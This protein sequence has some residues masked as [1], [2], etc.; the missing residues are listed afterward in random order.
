MESRIED[1]QNSLQD[2]HYSCH[3]K[4]LHNFNYARSFNTSENFTALSTNNQSNTNDSPDFCNNAKVTSTSSKRE[5]LR[6]HKGDRSL[7]IIKNNMWKQP[8][9][10]NRKV[11]T[12]RISTGSI[13]TKFLPFISHSTPPPPFN[14]PKNSSPLSA[15]PQQHKLHRSSVST[16]PSSPKITANQAVRVVTH[17]TSSQESPQQHHKPFYAC[18]RSTRSEGIITSTIFENQDHTSSAD[19]LKFTTSKSRVFPISE[20]EGSSPSD[21][22][23]DVN[24]SYLVTR[25]SSTLM[26]ERMEQEKLDIKEGTLV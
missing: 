14:S 7:T 17:T 16:P 25:N 20:T 24:K 19:P 13:P 22:L 4:Y 1:L 11:I 8:Q 15:V 3:G 2:I 10:G 6:K 18:H 21:C 9:P 5:P 12:H 23:E 26:N